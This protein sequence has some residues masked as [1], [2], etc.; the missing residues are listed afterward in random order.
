MFIA[1][2]SWLYDVSKHT[3]GGESYHTPDFTAEKS[4]TPMRYLQMGASVEE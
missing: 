3:W 1:N 2:K 4:E